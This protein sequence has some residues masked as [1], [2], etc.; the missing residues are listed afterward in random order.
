[1]D[2]TP[3][4]RLSLSPGSQS[5]HAVTTT[6]LSPLETERPDQ[7]SCY[8]ERDY[9]PSIKLVSKVCDRTD[10]LW[11]LFH[12]SPAPNENAPADFFDLP[13]GEGKELHSLDEWTNGTIE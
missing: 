1:M 9:R 4:V 13:L 12:G 2:T 7:E 3:F 5:L 6:L 11:P 8:L 10:R